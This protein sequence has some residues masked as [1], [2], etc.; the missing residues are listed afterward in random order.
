MASSRCAPGSG[1]PMPTIASS[2]ASPGGATTRASP[3]P[4]AATASTS[5]SRCAT[6]ASVDSRGTAA[7]SRWQAQTNKLSARAQPRLSRRMRGDW[8]FQ[9][10]AG[11]RSIRNSRV[12]QGYSKFGKIAAA[13]LLA[14]T[15]AAAA[16]GQAQGQA[17]GQPPAAAQEPAEA[18]SVDTFAIPDNI[19]ILGNDEL[20][21]RRAT[22]VVNGT[23]ITS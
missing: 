8:P 17:Q 19:T 2:S 13:A 21:E 14:G 1:S 22:A 12:K 11:A 6:S 7:A 20:G 23:I 3:M 16:Y 18:S 10:R 15:F 5:I 4:A 9:G